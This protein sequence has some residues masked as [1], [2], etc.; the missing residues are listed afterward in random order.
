MFKSTR[1]LGFSLRR[2][3]HLHEYQADQLLHSYD[4]PVLRGGSAK[5]PEDAYSVAKK[6]GGPV[7]IK[8]QVHAGGRGR[9]HFKNSGLQ[10]GV[11]I[12][13][14]SENIKAVARQM[15]QDVLITKQTGEEGKPVNTVFIVEK[16]DIKRELYIAL[17]LDR[18]RALPLLICSPKGGMGIEDI[19]KKYILKEYAQGLHGFS[20]KQLNQ[21]SKFL[22]LESPEQEAQMK[23][24]VKSLFKLMMER[25][26]TMVEINPMGV[27]SDGRIAVCDVKVNLDDNAKPRQKKLFE[28]EDLSQKDQK[29]VQAESNDLNYVKLK[30]TVGCLVNGAGLAMA[31]MDLINFRGGKPANFLDV[32]GTATSDR[33]KKAI[34]II[35]SD[36]EVK[37]IFIN[38]FG[39]IVRCDVVAQGVIE[40]VR[41]MNLQLPIVMRVKG[42][43][44][45]LADEL[46]K[47][48]GLKLYWCSDPE[49]AAEKAISFA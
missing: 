38:I 40:A 41:E 49:K 13:N 27:L 16:V 29:E 24:I 5:T 26:A 9:G 2:F 32:G 47:K 43:N 19:D 37:S 1:A 36:P 3:I 48:S 12:L 18:A 39:G 30:G 34:E 6:I 35:S 22:E 23:S 42:N 46:V 28:M 10:G 7:V 4:L 25:D 8:A 45:A 31:T 44:S 11:H 17:M 20:E 14:D 33:V 21:I 15:L